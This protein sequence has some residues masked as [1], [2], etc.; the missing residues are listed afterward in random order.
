MIVTYRRPHLLRRAAKSVQRQT[1]REWTCSI[2]N[3]DPEDERPRE[4]LRELGDTRFQLYQPNLKRG[5]ARAFNEAFRIQGYEFGA[6]LEDDNWWDPEFL[7]EM[8]AALW[9]HPKVS[10]A[11]GNERIWQERENQTWADTGKKIWCDPGNR[12]YSTSP[13]DACGSAK[14]C[15]SAM[16]WHIKP[17]IAFLTPEDIPVDVTEHFRERV[18]PQPILLV[19]K[20]MVNYAQTLST[21]RDRTGKIWGA[22]QALLIGSC[23]ASLPAKSRTG[24]AQ[25]LLAPFQGGCDP[26]VTSLLLAGYAVPEARVLL[27]LASLKQGL[28]FLVSLLAKPTKFLSLPLLRRN[29]TEHWT[30]LINSPFNQKLVK[31]AKK[32]K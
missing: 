24:L 17:G 12:L 31:P 13:E 28:R 22:Y 7:E 18:M 3:D 2:L 16:V 20:T 27:R 23:F 19:G 14:I 4:V 10:V 5:P 21:H 1:L 26:R 29:Y 15:N 30:F 6:L 9:D 8:T 25:S 11:C 32:E